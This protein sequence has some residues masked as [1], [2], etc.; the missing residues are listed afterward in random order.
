MR[1][2]KSVI[3]QTPTTTKDAVGGVTVVLNDVK[4]IP[5]NMQPYSSELARREYGLDK[6]VVIKI[7]C[8]PDEVVKLNNV[9]VDGTQK[10]KIVHVMRW[11]KHYE[12]LGEIL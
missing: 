10:Y 12:A 1:T 11:D 2:N 3:I 9:I 5:V 8:V 4:T 7:F 6:N